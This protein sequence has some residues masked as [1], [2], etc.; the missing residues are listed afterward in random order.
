ME[1]NATAT[2]LGVELHADVRGAEAL[3]D[4]LRPG[5]VHAAGDIAVLLDQRVIWAIQEAHVAGGFDL[6]FVTGA[7]QQFE[8]PPD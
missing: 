8:Q 7:T 2:R 1:K 3:D 4:T 5:E 6:G